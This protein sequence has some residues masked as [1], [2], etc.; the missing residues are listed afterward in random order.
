MR[1]T[2]FGATEKTFALG[3]ALR[4]RA[5]AYPISLGPEV[6]VEELLRAARQSGDGALALSVVAAPPAETARSLAALRDGLA[7]AVHV[8]IGGSG[9]KATPTPAGVER[10]ESLEQL[11]QRV[12]LLALERPRKH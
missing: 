1:K 12:G 4:P 9:A 7:P 5:G 2:A 6:P 10:I 8:W 3:S 11:E